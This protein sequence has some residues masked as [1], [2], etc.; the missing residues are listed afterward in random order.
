MEALAHQFRLAPT[1][2][3]RFREDGV[4]VARGVFGRR[5]AVRVARSLQDEPLSNR[6]D[7]IKGMKRFPF[8]TNKP[9]R[10]MVRDGPLGAAAAALL[11]VRS[12]RHYGSGLW[13]VAADPNVSSRQRPLSTTGWH[14]DYRFVRNKNDAAHRT[15][16]IMAWIALGHAP[17]AMQ[18]MPRSHLEHYRLCK[19]RAIFKG[20]AS[21]RLRRRS[22]RR[23]CAR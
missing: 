7:R 13:F 5:H 8:L 23:G 6:T 22:S 16:Y 15:P 11:G 20:L 14:T 21:T 2:V 9:F 12:V 18:Y 17:A 19:H 1:D 4:L 3:Q 10:E